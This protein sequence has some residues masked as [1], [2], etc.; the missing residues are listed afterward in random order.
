MLFDV[1]E[2]GKHIPMYVKCIIKFFVS[3]L[4]FS[5]FEVIT[6]VVEPVINEVTSSIREWGVIMKELFLVFPFFYFH[7]LSKGV[8]FIAIEVKGLFLKGGIS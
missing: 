3:L 4:H 1:L 5:P 8:F 7:A 2:T 6:P